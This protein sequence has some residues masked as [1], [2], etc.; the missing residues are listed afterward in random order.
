MK[1]AGDIGAGVVCVA[2]CQGQQH[3]VGSNRPRGRG[4]NYDIKIAEK[5]Y[6]ASE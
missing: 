1:L 5:I 6:K 2:G 4:G 3:G